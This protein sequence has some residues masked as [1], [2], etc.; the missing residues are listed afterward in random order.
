MNKFAIL[1]GALIFL[2]IFA[3]FALADSDDEEKNIVREGI[4]KG[5]GISEEVKE[6]IK[7]KA[8]EIEVRIR[9][10]IED[11]AAESKIKEEFRIKIKANDGAIEVNGKKVIRIKELDE[12][13]ELKE[14]IAGKIRAKTG[15]NLTT[16]DLANGSRLKAFLS[17]GQL[18]EIKIMPDSASG[19]ALARLRAKCAESNCSV[20]L[21]EVGK[22]ENVK[23]AYEIETEK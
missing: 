5:L 2:G 14:I 16:E 9:E 8:G 10:K 23:I 3:S 21:K 6:E 13:G 22:N 17:N 15:L 1:L 4:K 18:A 11:K 19:I 7:E 20:I 12:R